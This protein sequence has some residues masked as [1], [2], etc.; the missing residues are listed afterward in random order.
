MAADTAEA[1]AVGSGFAVDTGDRQDTRL[2]RGDRGTPGGEAAVD[3]GA[4]VAGEPGVAVADAEHEV[5]ATD[6]ARAAAGCAVVADR[7]SCSALTDVNAERL[8]RRHVD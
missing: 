1:G 5:D 4:A 8:A 2:G 3:A 6:Q 7:A